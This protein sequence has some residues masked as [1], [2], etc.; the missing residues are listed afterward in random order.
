MAYRVVPSLSALPVPPNDCTSMLV[1][2]ESGIRDSSKPPIKVSLALPARGTCLKLT[3]TF[4]CPGLCWPGGQPPPA[5]PWSSVPGRGQQYTQG[6][7]M[8]RQ[9][10]PDTE[11]Q[12][13]LFWGG[14]WETCQKVDLRQEADE[15]PQGKAIGDSFSIDQNSKTRKLGN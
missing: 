11:A 8:E 4:L 13:N 12:S 7:D 15:Y 10:E 3:L 5:H 6:R 2:P 14:R 9:A 1:V